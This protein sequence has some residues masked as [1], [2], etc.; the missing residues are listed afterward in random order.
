MGADHRR[1]EIYFL[2]QLL[3]GEDIT[4]ILYF[5]VAGV[6]LDS[7][8]VR[9]WFSSFLKQLS[10]NLNNLVISREFL[11]TNIVHEGLG[12]DILQK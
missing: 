12:N 10:I 5:G 6:T 8:G 3:P 11:Y 1:F 2:E 4:S 9:S 7:D